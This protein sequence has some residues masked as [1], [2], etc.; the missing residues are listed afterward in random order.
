MNKDTPLT[1]LQLEVQRQIREFADDPTDERARTLLLYIQENNSETRFGH[2]Y[3]VSAAA[4]E[5]VD[6]LLSGREVP[7]NKRVWKYFAITVAGTAVMTTVGDDFDAG[8]SE[9]R[10]QSLT[11]IL[12]CVMRLVEEQKQKFIKKAIEQT[13][14]NQGGLNLMRRGDPEPKKN[15]GGFAFNL[16][17]RKPVGDA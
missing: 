12:D 17:K 5:A 9:Q 7:Q 16:F 11:C 10:Y 14:S 4:R 8:V 1:P 13:M 2:V 6:G 15:S 3:E